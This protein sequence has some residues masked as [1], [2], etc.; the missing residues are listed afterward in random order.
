M[1]TWYDKK[2]HCRFRGTVSIYNMAPGWNAAK[3]VENVHA[4]YAGKSESDDQCITMFV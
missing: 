1:G 3:G 4:L 2:D